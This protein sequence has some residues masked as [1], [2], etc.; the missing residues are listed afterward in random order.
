[1]VHDERVAVHARVHR[2]I[3]VHRVAERADDERQVGETRSP[4]R[5]GTAAPCVRRTRS[6]A[7]EVHL[8]RR[9]ARARSWPSTGPC[10]PRSA[11]GCCRTGCARRPWRTARRRRGRRRGAVPASAAV[12][13]PAGAPVRRSTSRTGDATALAGAGDRRR[14]PDRARRSAAGRRGDVTRLGR[15]RC[16]RVRRGPA[17]PE[18]ARRAAVPER[19]VAASAAAGAVPERPPVPGRGGGAGAGADPAAGAAAALGGA[20]PD[21][22]ARRHRRRATASRAPTSTVS[23][24]GTTISVSTPA[25]GDGTSE[26]TLSVDTSNSGSSSATWSPTCLSHR[27]MVPSVTVSPSWGIVT[28]TVPS[29]VVSRAAIDR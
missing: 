7:L 21:A 5:P 28:S 8:D 9:V 17:V 3:V 26:S 13:A 14:G 22:S 12:R 29:S 27:V 18:R 16:S 20:V 11:A 1:M 25:T 6:T 15:R 2:G 19:P 23:P 24:S 10:A 4:R